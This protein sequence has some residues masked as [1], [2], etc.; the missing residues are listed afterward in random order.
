[1]EA[2]AAALNSRSDE[3]EGSE[4]APRGREAD[5]LCFWRWRSS[6]RLEHC[7]EVGVRGG[8]QRKSRGA[9]SEAAL[10]VKTF[11]C[12]KA[13][14][15]EAALR[16]WPAQLGF[17]VRLRRLS[18]VFSEADAAALSNSGSP[19]SAQALERIATVIWRAADKRG[20][21]REELAANTAAAVGQSRRPP[22][23]SSCS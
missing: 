10:R 9:V 3:G 11:V 21:L 18:D 2:T 22:R 20:E 5:A 16:L 19:A 23:L 8:L 15:V 14:A 12:A 6:V 17:R 4:E 13:V 7:V 1:M